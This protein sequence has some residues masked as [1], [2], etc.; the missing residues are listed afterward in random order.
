MPR[1]NSPKS[2]PDVSCGISD[3]DR[4]D[5]RLAGASRGARLTQAD[6]LLGTA[7]D[8]EPDGGL[9]LRADLFG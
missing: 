4:A 2:L 6:G 5:C 1:G 9:V 8:G 7:A 3:K